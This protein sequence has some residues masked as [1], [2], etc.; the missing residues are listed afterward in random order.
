MPI[1]DV[2]ETSGTAI[3]S[4]YTGNTPITQFTFANGQVS[5]AARP[6]SITLSLDAFQEQLDAIALW[7]MLVNDKL[8]PAA[9][10]LEEFMIEVVRDT[11]EIKAEYKAGS[12]KLTEATRA[13]GA[14]SITFAARPAYTMPWSD[15][16]RWYCF[17]KM[18]RRDCAGG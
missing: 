18:V 9:T 10:D 11:M 16:H 17:L 5:L 8:S 12:T 4:L 15:F 1:L 2:N 13:N 6:N 3:L 7:V 14:N